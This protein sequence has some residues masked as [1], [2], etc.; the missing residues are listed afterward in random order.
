MTI[1]T[2]KSLGPWPVKVLSV[3]GQSPLNVVKTR[4]S[5]DYDYRYSF[6]VAS[7]KND[8]SSKIKIDVPHVYRATHMI[9]FGFDQ[10]ALPKLTDKTAK[11]APEKS[12]KQL[13]TS[14][15]ASGVADAALIA[16]AKKQ[17]QAAATKERQL[18]QDRL[19]L[20][21]QNQ[22]GMLKIL[23]RIPLKSLFLH[24]IGTPLK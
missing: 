17:S 16:Q 4:H 18:A 3:A 15:A 11:R 6:K 5:S 20:N 22:Q 21:K 19:L 2:K 7:L 13:S 12:N 1:R 10:A 9:S 24:S 23:M 8:V 14:K